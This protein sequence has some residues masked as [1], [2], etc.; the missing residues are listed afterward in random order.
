MMQQLDHQQE[1]YGAPVVASSARGSGR[2]MPQQDHQQESY[3]APVVASS[4]RPRVQ[5]Q[6]TPAG[7]QHLS[8]MRSGK[9]WLHVRDPLQPFGKDQV[10]ALLEDEGLDDGR[11]LVRNV[12]GKAEHYILSVVYKGKPTHHPIA[13]NDSGRL[14]LNKSTWNESRTIEQLVEALE[15]TQ[16]GWPVPLDKPVWMD[17]NAH[18]TKRFNMHAVPTAGPDPFASSDNDDRE[19]YSYLAKHNTIEKRKKSPRSDVCG[20]PISDVGDGRFLV[21]AD[22]NPGAYWL[23][24]VYHGRPTHHSVKPNSRTGIMEINKTS[25]TRAYSIEE[26][27]QSLSDASACKMYG[28]PAPLTQAVESNYTTT[29]WLHFRS[30]DQPFSV[31]DVVAKFTAEGMDD[32][33]FL[34]RNVVGK[35]DEFVISVVYQGKP[36]HHNVITNAKGLLEI[37]GE[38]YGKTSCLAGLVAELSK[39]A[40]QNIN[41]P[42]KLDKP[43]ISGRAAAGQTGS[44]P[45]WLHDPV[46]TQE[47][48]SALLLAMGEGVYAELCEEPRGPNGFCKLH[49]CPEAASCQRQGLQCFLSKPAEYKLCAVC[50]VRRQRPDLVDMP[51]VQEL[52]DA[53]DLN[54]LE[55]D[56]ML[57]DVPKL[58][59]SLEG[60][61]EESIYQF[62]DQGQ[63]RKRNGKADQDSG[64]FGEFRVSEKLVLTEW[65]GCDQTGKPVKQAGTLHELRRLLNQAKVLASGPLTQAPLIAIERVYNEALAEVNRGNQGG[66]KGYTMFATWVSKGLRDKDVCCDDGSAAS[67]ATLQQPTPPI[68]EGASK[69]F[70]TSLAQLTH[71]DQMLMAQFLDFA[72]AGKFG[73]ITG[74]NTDNEDLYATVHALKNGFG[75]TVMY[76]DYIQARSYLTKPKYDAW[77][78]KLIDAKVVDEQTGTPLA[79]VVVATI[80]PLARATF[81]AMAY[82]LHPRPKMSHIKDWVRLSVAA[83]TLPALVASFFAIRDECESP[84]ISRHEVELVTVKVRLARATHDIVIVL[85]FNGMLCECQLH[86]ASLLRLRDLTHIPSAVLRLPNDNPPAPKMPVFIK[87]DDG[88]GGWNFAEDLNPDNFELVI[89]YKRV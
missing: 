49:S 2:I 81:K 77:M 11:F 76:M 71:T 87:S 32:G 84:T 36:T 89:S 60:I 66:G 75:E 24:V 62:V 9:S 39:P 44:S 29:P 21:R 64:C 17:A 51:G 59:A 48:V 63:F 5:S 67:I 31:K 86:L 35:P 6:R 33:R 30:A 50:T 38:A 10:E 23:S 69:I 55:R 61:L 40:S 70:K 88:D 78:T 46:L 58:Q 8:S 3:G 1:S 15:Y 34:V 16:A 68:F 73:S 79:N 42:V 19:M 54:P 4:A 47:Q 20:F 7:P 41:W 27:V 57:R 26:V 52:I 25:L 14:V 80:K 72:D 45:V 28:W 53:D 22:N 83:Q 12:L 56:R 65:R 18:T 13:P 85:K 82:E 74:E 43:I 37:N